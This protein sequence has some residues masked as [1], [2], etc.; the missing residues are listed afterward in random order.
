MSDVLPIPQ[1]S[2]LEL[3]ARQRIARIC[4]KGTFTEICGPEARRKSPHLAT[5]GMPS[6]FDDGLIVG[7]ARL[8]GRNIMVA[9]QEGAFM[10]GAV[11]EVHGAKLTGLLLRAADR[12]PEAVV[13]LAD[14]GGV[15]LHEANAGLVAVGEIQR[16]IFTA[17][18][19]GVPVIA[20]IG[21][22]N[23][24]YGGMSIAAR[25][26]DWVVMSG[27]GRL[28]VSGPEVIESA[29]GAGEFDARDRA[30]VWRTMGGRHRYLM[31]DADRLVADDP[32]AFRSEIVSLLGQSRAI[33]L[34]TLR[35][36]NTEL[37]Q[38]IDTFGAARDGTEIWQAM[39][40]S[41]PWRLPELE[42][43]PFQ[44]AVDGKRRK[45]A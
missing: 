29:Q 44:A 14:S 5:F 24:C 13:I 32:G 1:D 7:E 6:A 26:C 12:A 45:R 10:G 16:A 31:G 35:A 41:D 43:D 3:S 42:P 22:A 15:R 25:S 27:E 9:A 36:R 39:G 11:G 21:S 34:E 23:G 4:D 38:R 37:K 8:D 18:D 30:L 33:T 2:Y 17:R 28:S 40:H 20:V 19:A